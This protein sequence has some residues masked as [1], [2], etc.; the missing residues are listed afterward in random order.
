[1][2]I[3]ETYNTLCDKWELKS[4]KAALMTYTGEKIPGLGEVLI[5]V[6]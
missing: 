6:K 2:L 5:P 4:S 1:M 3:E